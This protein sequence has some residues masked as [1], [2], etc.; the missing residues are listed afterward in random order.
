[1]VRIT[2]TVYFDPQLDPGLV[3][4]ALD[5]ALD[6][7]AGL[8]A[9]PAP[10]VIFAGLRERGAEYRLR[11][12]IDDYGERDRISEAVWK[13]VIETARRSG[14]AMVLPRQYVQVA[15]DPW[16]GEGTAT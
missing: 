11:Y 10:S 14:L 15:A 13:A 16:Q 12:F 4:S 7:L 3:Q 5:A 8:L 2:D 9:G 1:V 6:D